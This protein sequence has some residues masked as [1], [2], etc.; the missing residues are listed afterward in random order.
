MRYGVSRLGRARSA[1]QI[2]VMAKRA[3]NLLND[4]YVEERGP[5]RIFRYLV[6]E[7]STEH[8]LEKYPEA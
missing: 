5:G 6:K 2:G 3:Q 1:D 7:V 8:R 4:F